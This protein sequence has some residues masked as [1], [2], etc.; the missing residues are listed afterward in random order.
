LRPLADTSPT[1]LSGRR[2]DA[3]STST[4]PA[5]CRWARLTLSH[6]ARAP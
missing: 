6:G 5:S 4:A 1:R 2:T 3:G